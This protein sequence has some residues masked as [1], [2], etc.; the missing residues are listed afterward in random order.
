M[1]DQPASLAAVGFVLTTAAAVSLA[2]CFPAYA[3]SPEV[4][5]RPD[6]D[7]VSFEV[8]SWGAP[9]S[10]WRIL[11]NGGGSWTETLRAKGAAHYDYKLA[12]HEIEPDPFNYIALE[13]ILR[14]L[15]D[16]APDSQQCDSFISDMAYGTIRLTHGAT[17]IEVAWNDGCMDET[18]RAFMAVLKQADEHMQALGKAA[19]VTRTE[20]PPVDN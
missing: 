4:P 14:H 10:S 11:S 17:T 9:V 3:E 13:K 16:P 19:P 1:V 5:P 6:W 12:W 8:M 2:G 18:Y 20:S 7:F 15:P